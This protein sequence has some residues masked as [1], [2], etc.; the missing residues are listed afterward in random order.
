MK[1]L[2]LKSNAFNKGEVL[3]RAQLKKV[4]G[5]NESGSGD[6]CND[7]ATCKVVITG[8]VDGE[9]FTSESTGTC[10]KDT[11]GST[12]TCYCSAAGGKGSLTSNGGKSRCWV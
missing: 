8:V 12:I 5:G 3:T 11:F 4:M 1:K 2:S 10:S 7:G 6:T 9:P